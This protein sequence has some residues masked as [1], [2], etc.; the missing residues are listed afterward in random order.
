MHQ[1]IIKIAIFFLAIFGEIW[2][3]N[4]YWFIGLIFEQILKFIKNPNLIGMSSNFLNKIKTCTCI[5]KNYKNGE[6][7]PS[8]FW[9]NL[10]KDPV[11]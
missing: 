2:P 7:S 6:L 4:L 11:L 10:A 9:R 1:K 5:R 8:H 3:N